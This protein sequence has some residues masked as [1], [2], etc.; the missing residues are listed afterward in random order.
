MYRDTWAVFFLLIIGTAVLIG[1]DY[2]IV[3][4]IDPSADIF[5]GMVA[6]PIGT[7]GV[8]SCLFLV[9]YIYW[10]VADLIV[11]EFL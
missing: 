2:L 4:T 7:L 8:L 5:A 1:V 9:F 10:S 6:L 3:V 11:E